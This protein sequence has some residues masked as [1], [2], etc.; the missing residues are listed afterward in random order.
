[1]IKHLFSLS[2]TLIKQYLEENG[3]DGLYS[4][5]GECGCE[6]SDLFPCGYRPDD[7][8]PGYKVPCN[9]ACGGDWHIGPKMGS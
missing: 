5:D 9:C 2:G 3:Y 1:M 7:C 6:N 4:I 8:T